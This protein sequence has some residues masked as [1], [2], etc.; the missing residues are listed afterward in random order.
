M[1]PYEFIEEVMEEMSPEEQKAWS[2]S[3]IYPH[4]AF[5]AV[6]IAGMIAFIALA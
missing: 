5:W 3:I 6:A 4:L 2:A 1:L